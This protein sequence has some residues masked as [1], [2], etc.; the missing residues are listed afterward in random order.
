MIN[1]SHTI[2]QNKY[3]Q[4]PEW[5]FNFYYSTIN[6]LLINYYMDKIKFSSCT[7][8]QQS[9]FCPPVTS[10]SYILSIIII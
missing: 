2:D 4:S 7:T 3:G 5:Y 8:N 10:S 9:S 6:Q 1:N